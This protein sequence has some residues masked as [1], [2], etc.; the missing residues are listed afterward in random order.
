M[1]YNKKLPYNDLPFLPPK[2]EIETKEILKKAITANKALAKL[3][4]SGKQLPNQSILIN[5]I[6]LQEAKLSSEIEN[7]LTTNDELYQA[8]ASDRKITDPGTKEVLHYQEALWEG[9]QWVKKNGLLTT[10]LIVSLCNLIRETDAGIRKTPGTKIINHKTGEVIYTPPEGEDVIRTKLKNLEEYINLDDDGVDPLIKMAVA[11]Y[12][13][14]AIHP[15]TDGNGRT[16]RIL[17]ILY[18]VKNNLLEFPILYL[19]KYIIDHKAKYYTA[20]RSIT[21]KNDWKDWILYVLDGVEQ[22]ALYTQNKIDAI[23][24]L[25]KESEEYIKKKLPDIYSKE[26]VEIIFRQPYCKRKF[27]EDAHLVKRKTAGVYLSELERVGVF[28]SE[29]VGKEKL[30]INKKLFDILK[31]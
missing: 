13:F 10:N 7:I 6:V 26:L 11:H 3:V 14:E 18:L 24:A 19:S 23:I 9:Y 16:G 17:N 12:Q 2:G 28:K 25:Q 15:F 21:E 5:S 31:K 4:G 29:K 8:F 27:L 20:L 30:Y 22:T 1:P